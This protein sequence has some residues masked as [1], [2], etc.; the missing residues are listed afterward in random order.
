MSNWDYLETAIFSGSS[1]EAGQNITKYVKTAINTNDGVS[2]TNRIWVE[3]DD[4]EAYGGCEMMPTPVGYIYELRD[5]EDVKKILRQT[6]ELLLYLR[7]HTDLIKG[8][9]QVEDSNGS[10]SICLG[11]EKEKEATIVLQE[12]KTEDVLEDNFELDIDKD[13]SDIEEEGQLDFD[14][15]E[16]SGSCEEIECACTMEMGDGGNELPEYLPDGFDEEDSTLISE[17]IIDTDEE[18]EID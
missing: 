12:K 16:I 6:A 5:Q 10:I 9:L 4:P 17:E 7:N 18:F 11:W 3:S 8:N 1:S 14:Y 15:E 2:I 13:E